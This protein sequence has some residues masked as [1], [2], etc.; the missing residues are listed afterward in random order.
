MAKNELIFQGKA[1]KEFTVR[2]RG[3]LTRI[4]LTRDMTRLFRDV[5]EPTKEESDMFEFLYPDYPE[6]EMR[7]MDIDQWENEEEMKMMQGLANVALDIDYARL[8][9]FGVWKAV[10]SC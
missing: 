3:K 4:H 1:S 8:K 9:R 10:S 7:V 2:W 5:L 6:S